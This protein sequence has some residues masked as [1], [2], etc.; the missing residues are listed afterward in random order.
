MLRSYLLVISIRA[1]KKIEALP[2][3]KKI[4]NLLLT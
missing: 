4:C 3:A 1:S 2:F